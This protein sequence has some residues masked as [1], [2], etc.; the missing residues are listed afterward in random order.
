MSP[1][2]ITGNLLDYCSD[3]KNVIVQE[4]DSVSLRPFNLSEEI[5]WKWTGASYGKRKKINTTTNTNCSDSP[6]EIGKIETFDTGNGLVCNFISKV[7]PGR[8]NQFRDH[9]SRLY[10]VYSCIDYDKDD[11]KETREILFKICLE[12]LKT[13]LEEEKD[14]YTKDMKIYFPKWIGCGF[15]KGNWSNYYGY[16]KDFASSV[17]NDVNI[18]EKN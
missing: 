5:E 7:Y 2:E 14:G 6:S 9:Y 13:K 1:I 8:P 4:L 3:K 11:S 12:E 16:I 17:R 10:K 15:S 18:V